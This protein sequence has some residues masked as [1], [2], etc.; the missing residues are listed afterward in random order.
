[1]NWI[2]LDEGRDKG[3]A[4]MITATNLRVSRAVRNFLTGRETD[5]FS[6][7][8]LLVEFV[9]LILVFK[10]L[11]IRIRLINKTYT[12]HYYNKNQRDALFL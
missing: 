7:M 1:M 11:W 4:V 2:H 3:Q 8:A 12:L 9:R 10:V 5:N 6:G